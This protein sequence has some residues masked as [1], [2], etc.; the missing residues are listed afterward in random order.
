[1]VY[2]VIFEDDIDFNGWVVMVVEDFVVDNVNNG[3]Y[4]CFFMVEEF[5][6]CFL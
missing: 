6:L 1:M 2:V 5:D 4:I 3:G